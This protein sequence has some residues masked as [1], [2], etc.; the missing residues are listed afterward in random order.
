[1]WHHDWQLWWP[2]RFLQRYVHQMITGNATNM[3][4]RVIDLHTS[5]QWIKYRLIG[6]IQDLCGRLKHNKVSS[7]SDLPMYVKSWGLLLMQQ[8]NTVNH[9]STTAWSSDQTPPPSMSPFTLKN[10]HALDFCLWL[11][12]STCEKP[13]TGLRWETG[14]LRESREVKSTHSASGAL[15]ADKSCW[16]WG[17]KGITCDCVYGMWKTHTDTRTH[18]RTPLVALQR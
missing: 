6:H 4:T 16:P 3:N 11:Y 13:E 18:T 5:A 14:R 2:M 7:T 12:S 9:G 1:M 8:L 10:C 15:R 17:C